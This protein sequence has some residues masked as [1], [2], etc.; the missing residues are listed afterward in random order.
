MYVTEKSKAIT[1]IFLASIMLA[2]AISNTLDPLSMARI[3]V[4]LI[5]GIPGA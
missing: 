2:T 1:G 4:A 5:M 3:V